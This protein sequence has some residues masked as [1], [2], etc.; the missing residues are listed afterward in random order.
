ME[1]LARLD[2]HGGRLRVGEA[3]TPAGLRNIEL[4]FFLQ[5][6]LREHLAHMAAL[7][8]VASADAPIFPTYRGGQHSAS[9]IR[10]RLLTECI[11]RANA[12]R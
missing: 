4:T 10:N 2:L 9:N 8:R 5:A 1:L 6:E 12:R 3:K 7:G 11:A